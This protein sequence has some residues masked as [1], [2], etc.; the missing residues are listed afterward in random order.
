MKNSKRHHYIPKFLIKNFCNE[1]GFVFVY[2]KE[3]DRILKNPQSPKSIFFENHRNTSFID[4]ISNDQIEKMYS[5]ID[6]DLAIHISSI[7][8]SN[9]FNS[10]EFISLVYLYLL[11]KWRVPHSDVKFDMLKETLTNNDLRVEI[12]SNGNNDDKVNNAIKDLISSDLYKDLKRI[13]LPTSLLEKSKELT[14]VSQ[15][16]WLLTKPNW[17]S[18]LDDYPV[19]DHVKN[20]SEEILNFILPLSSE[21]S[22]VFV[23]DAIK[24]V[25]DNAFFMNEDLLQLHNAEKYVVCKN[26]VHLENMIGIYKKVKEDKFEDQIQDFIF[27]YFV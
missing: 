22:Y 7:L 8:K 15:N 12:R 2:D 25:P 19:I 3:N 20:K 10:E 27:N 24:Q 4:G 6:N 5:A 9:K 23:K 13:I 18:L 21:V 16:N 1:E 26:R 17:N 14:I 11:L